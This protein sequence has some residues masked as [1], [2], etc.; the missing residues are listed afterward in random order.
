MQKDVISK[1]LDEVAS[2]KVSVKDARKALEEVELDEETYFRAI[3]HGVFNPAEAGT[4]VNA[5]LAPSGGSALAILFFVWGIFWTLFWIGNML[6]GLF[7]GWDQ[8]ILSFDFAMAVTTVIMMGIVYM[9]WILPDLVIIKHRR[10]KYV[11]EHPKDWVEY[12]I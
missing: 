11:R 3:D 10:N 6:Y 9:K 2:G 5:S 1:L 7:N 8:Q 12:K 4:I